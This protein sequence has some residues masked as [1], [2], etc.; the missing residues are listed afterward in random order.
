MSLKIGGSTVYRGKTGQWAFVSHRVTGFLVFMFLM[1]HIVDVSLI[2]IDTD[3]YDEVHDLYGNVLLRI[4]ECGLLLALLYHSLNGIRIVLVDFFPGAI[5]NEK[6][7]TGV[8]TFLTLAVGIPGSL[9]ILWPFI[10]GT[11]LN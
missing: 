2:N 6:A 8:V 11:I 4:F 9:V 7:L 1:L 10:D 3:L 5:K